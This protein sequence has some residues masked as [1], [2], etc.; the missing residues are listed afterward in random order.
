[1]LADKT[2]SSPKVGIVVVVFI[3][4]TTAIALGINYRYLAEY[5]WYFSAACSVFLGA[6]FK[7]FSSLNYDGKTNLYYQHIGIANYITLLRGGCICIMSGFVGSSLN[8]PLACLYLGVVVLDVVD[9]FVAR[10]T[11]HISV[12]GEKMD[13]EC[14]ALGMFV[15]TLI[16]VQQQQLPLAYVFVGLFRY[17]FVLHLLGRRNKKSFALPPSNFRRFLAGLHMIFIAISLFP[18][19]KPS[20]L[21]PMSYVFALPFYVIFIRDWW[22]VIGILPDH[23][24]YY[25]YLN[26]FCT[27]CCFK[28]V[29]LLLSIALFFTFAADLTTMG[30]CAILFLC[31]VGN[32][33]QIC[34]R[35][36]SLLVIILFCCVVIFMSPGLYTTTALAIIVVFLGSNIR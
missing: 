3:I 8:L 23:K 24:G 11:N 7:R 30:V 32:L 12:F 14:D 34:V 27:L 29:P 6:L 10:S 36:M 17:F 5:K 26:G 31:A 25:K 20:T 1:M 19:V 33:L 4:M 28:V 16:C 35:F 21:A 9:G 15:A 18:M 13:T 2:S 22:W